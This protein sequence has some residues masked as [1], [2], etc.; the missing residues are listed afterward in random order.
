MSEEKALI[1]DGTRNWADGILEGVFSE[2]Q[3]DRIL[4][5]LN[6]TELVNV[7]LALGAKKSDV[8]TQLVQRKADHAQIQ[9]R[10][11][12]T[13]N[14]DEWFRADAEYQT[15]RGKAIGFKR[16][17]ETALSRVK[18]IQHEEERAKTDHMERLRELVRTARKFVPDSISAW[19]EEA[20]RI[21]KR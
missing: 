7:R 5:K 17:I 13:R 18:A 14:N 16:L 15:W 6:S 9:V 4:A 10:C 19:H 2:D 11:W 3:L 21:V 1:V 8:E 20:D 12:N